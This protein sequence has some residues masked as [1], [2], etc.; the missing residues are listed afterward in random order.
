M[1]DISMYEVLK[2][3]NQIA[4]EAKDYAPPD[5]KNIGLKREELFNNKNEK[6][7]Q[8]RR[9]I[10]GFAVNFSGK[11]MRV[12]YY[13]S[14]NLDE[15]NRD[16]EYFEDTVLTMIEKIV[17][18]I[19]SEFQKRSKSSLSLKRLRDSAF[20]EVSA[21]DS[22]VSQD[23]HY[24]GYVDYEIKNKVNDTPADY[25]ERFARDDRKLIKEA[26]KKITKVFRDKFKD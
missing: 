18:Y 7:I 20:V 8:D 17:S 6:K 5:N 3:I 24:K 25:R 26:K 23:I 16:K 1:S 22:M 10:D 11:I 13:S 4:T 2:I 9:V 19:K 15:I 12:I 14:A 21:N